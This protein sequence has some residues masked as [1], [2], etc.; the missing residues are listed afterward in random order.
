MMANIPIDL[1]I[2]AYVDGQLDEP[3]RLAMLSRLASDANLRQQVAE[4]QMLKALVLSSYPVDEA[5]AV[6]HRKRRSK[7]TLSNMV[8][9]FVLIVAVSVGWLAHSM[10]HPVSSGVVVPL[11]MAKGDGNYLVQMSLGNEADWQNSVSGIELL[12]MK[13]ETSQVELLVNDEAISMLDQHS[14]VAN[15]L[16][17][18]AQETNRLKLSVCKQGLERW[19]SRGLSVNLIS[20][21]DTSHSALEGVINRLKEG[22]YLVPLEKLTPA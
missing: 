13:S 8:A 5:N 14:P 16:Q 21:V 9:S 2:H 20:G 6:F 1:D 4:L 3:A 22:W 18:L 19:R 15:K 10:L 17:Q 12:L 11:S 7:S